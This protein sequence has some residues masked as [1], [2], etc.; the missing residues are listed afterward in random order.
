MSCDGA[1]RKLW[2]HG[3][4]WYRDQVSSEVKDL[5]EEALGDWLED[6]L[7]RASRG[8][9]GR[10]RKSGGSKTGSTKKRQSST[11]QRSAAAP[12]SRPAPQRSTTDLESMFL[13]VKAA[14]K[15]R[16]R[17]WNA[18]E[19]RELEEKY[20]QLKLWLR[21]QGAPADLN[22]AHGAE[23]DYPRISSLVAYAA[24][25]DYIDL[26]RQSAKV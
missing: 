26:C 4:G 10:R 15:D 20:D 7:D 5:I 18:D 12:R 17:D 25:W 24:V 11:A 1:R 16:D 14:A 8:G 22:P 19:R 3:E 13:D 9:S 23:E 6:Q 21:E 2:A